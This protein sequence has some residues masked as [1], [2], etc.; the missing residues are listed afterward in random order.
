MRAW[1]LFFILTVA[2]P[3]VAADIHWQWV[4]A[5]YTIN[6]WSVSRGVAEVSIEGD[7]FSATLFEEGSYTDVQ[8]TLAGLIENGKIKV[9]EIIH[10]SD[11]TGSKYEGTL[12]KKNWENFVGTSGAESINLSDGW[13][14]IGIKRTLPK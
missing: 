13:S 7:K 4:K 2:T 3:S 9:T 1:I 12:T 10:G 11:Y 8:I 5:S 14:M 6:E